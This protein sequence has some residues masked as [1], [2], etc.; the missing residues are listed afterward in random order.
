MLG[1]KLNHVSKRAPGSLSQD[2]SANNMITT[3]MNLNYMDFTPVNMH[4]NMHTSILN[5]NNFCYCNFIKL[6]LVVSAF[7]ERTPRIP[8]ISAPYTY[9]Q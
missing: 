5:S 6:K 3:E 4:E 7:Y 9:N 2:G 8:I 1:L